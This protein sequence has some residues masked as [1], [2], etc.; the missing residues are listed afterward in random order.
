M[1][2]QN[3]KIICESD[4]AHLVNI[5]TE[6]ELTALQIYAQDNWEQFDYGEWTGAER[7]GQDFYWPGGNFKVDD[8]MWGEQQPSLTPTSEKCVWAATSGPNTPFLL[9]DGV[10]WSLL[11]FLCEMN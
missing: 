2:I 8:R 6:D 10:C 7:S 1:I 11:Y 4:G 5:E 3:V 9:G